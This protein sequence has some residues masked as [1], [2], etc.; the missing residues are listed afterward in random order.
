MKVYY[1]IKTNSKKEK[2]KIIPYN[3]NID[4]ALEGALKLGL[5]CIPYF[6]VE[7]IIDKYELGD[8]VLDGV[9]QVRYCLK[10][11]GITPAEFDYPD[12]LKP[13]LGRNIKK[14]KLSEFISNDK[15]LSKGY[16]VKPVKQKL[17]T[18]KRVFSYK[19][20]IGISS[21][22][23]D[24]GI[25]LSE[26]LEFVYELRSF[27]Y[28]DKIIDIRPYL[29][30]GIEY[31]KYLDTTLIEQ[32]MDNWKKWENRPN[33]CSLDWGI[34]KIKKNN[35]YIYKTVLIEANLPYA[36]GNYGLPAVDYIKLINAYISQISGIE[37]ELHF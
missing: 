4:I 6:N 11:F 25:Y 13:Y 33:S 10:K 22:E 12:V 18:G 17:F 30:K 7:E 29:H 20:V 9:Y 34:A 26:P 8:I 36:L 14:I 35:E 24:L 27:V 19:D 31:L 32:A 1:L 3:S 23:E 21:D 37:D 28:Y 15:L 5:E 2:D 16:F